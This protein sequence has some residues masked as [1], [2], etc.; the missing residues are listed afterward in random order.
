MKMKV[1][2]LAGSSVPVGKG[3][4][5]AAQGQAYRLTLSGKFFLPE[6]GRAVREHWPEYLIEATGLG[7]F[8]I[9]A[10]FFAALI[11]HPSSPVNRT[12]TTPLA[13]RTLMGMMMGLTAIA[14]IYSPWGKRSGAHINPS[15][16]LAFLRLG[17]IT[18]WD[19]GL[20]L[21]AQFAGAVSG[22]LISALLLGSLISDAS[23][24]YVTTAPGPHGVW[25]AFI[26]EVLISFIL[27]TAILLASNHRRAARSTGVIAGVLVATY[28]AIESPISGMS[29]NP[30]RTFGS[31]FGAR[32]WT[33]IWLYFTAPPLGMLLAAELYMR[34]RGRVMCAK[35]HHQNN[36]RCIFR[37]GY[38]KEESHEKDT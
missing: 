20:Y 18:P 36:Q 28:I 26:A 14:I 12:I 33:A 32:S 13:Q 37:C 38:K 21:V 24:N 35:L 30:A 6:M 4:A 34:T 3:G 9:S 7:F 16:T 15:T 5:E 17:K 19:A 25:V 22:I 1:S 27:M 23:V 11:F 29:M 31:A 2:H 10:C 8:M